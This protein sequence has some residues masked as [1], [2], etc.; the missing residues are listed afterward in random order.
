MIKMEIGQIYKTTKE[1]I[2]GLVNQM[3]KEFGSNPFRQKLEERLI[4]ELVEKGWEIKKSPVPDYEDNLSYL[5]SLLPQ[6]YRV[7]KTLSESQ[8]KYAENLVQSLLAQ[9]KLL[10]SLKTT[11]KKIQQLDN[12]V[13]DLYLKTRKPANN[14]PC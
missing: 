3:E 11:A 8:H 6:L 7:T 5:L 4:E 13:L 12:S 14:L 1:D 10:N 9:E 2:T